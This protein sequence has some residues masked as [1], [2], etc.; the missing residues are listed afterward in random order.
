MRIEGGAT[1]STA[2]PE[3]KAAAEKFE[4]V[5][6]RQLLGEMRRA[7]LSDDVFGSE[8][9]NQ[10][11]ELADANTADALAAKGAFGIGALVAGQ[12]AR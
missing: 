2:K 9:T 5:F 12:F 8:A 3:L 11:R 7:K 10:F 1:Q 4:A 6:V